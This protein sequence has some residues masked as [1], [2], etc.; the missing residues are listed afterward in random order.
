MDDFSCRVSVL[1]PSKI[2][3]EIHSHPE[4]ELLIMLSGKLEVLLQHPEN[5]PTEK[6]ERIERGDFIYYNAFQPHTIHNVGT[7]PATY[8]MFKWCHEETSKNGTQLETTIFHYGIGADSPNNIFHSK[9]F[10]NPTNYL[11]NLHCHVTA[12][13]PDAGYPPHSDAYDVAILMLSGIIETLGRQVEPHSVIFYSA[14]EPHGMKNIGDVQAFYLVFEF[15]NKH[16]R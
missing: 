11:Q 10:E 4:E 3:H 14:G 9:I 5:E 7:E 6:K 15:H 2:P 16:A 13:Q 1:G 12:L 8:L